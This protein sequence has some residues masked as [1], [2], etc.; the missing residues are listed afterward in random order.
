MGID[1]NYTIQKGDNLWN[2]AKKQLQLQNGQKPTNAQIVQAMKDIAQA[3]GCETV[4]ECKNKFFY[5]VGSTI[6]LTTEPQG[7]T[8]PAKQEITAEQKTQIDQ[9]RQLSYSSDNFTAEIDK[10]TN[11]NTYAQYLLSNESFKVEER[12]TTEDNSVYEKFADK[13]GKTIGSIYRNPQGN[14]ER[15]DMYLADESVLHLIVDEGET[16]GECSVTSA[17]K[18]IPG[19][20]KNEF[21][22]T[23]KNF[24]NHKNNY[25]CRKEQVA[26]IILEHYT[27]DNRSVA[28]I[29]KNAE[30]GEILS[31]HLESESTN[32]TQT[33]YFYSDRNG[34]G[35]ITPE[36]GTVQ[37]HKRV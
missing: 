11:I 9:L 36:D 3:N 6:N 8:K 23:Y 20:D 13:N 7:T 22:D 34:D 17:P 30:T 15:I 21:C 16:L 5:R 27:D 4:E 37:Y 32:N 12:H 10:N 18:T 14:I 33:S 35:K 29:S 26:D 19:A 24:M 25:F 31:I 1:N 2:I 28:T